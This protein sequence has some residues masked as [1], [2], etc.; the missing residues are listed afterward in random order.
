MGCLGVH[1]ALDERDL[2][3]LR[4][5]PN[6]EER[7]NYLQETIEEND[8]GSKDGWIAETDKAW[9]AIHR[10]LTDGRLGSDN[11]TYPLNHTILGGE[12]LYNSH[13]YIMQLKTPEEVRAIAV[14]LRGI[15]EGEFHQR[16]FRIDP[17]DYGMPLS[18][19]DFEYS[20]SWFTSM[21]EFYERAATAGRSVLFTASQ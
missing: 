5:Q 8:I 12:S 11:G 10:A 17:D 14:E 16:Y 2:Q 9:D 19:D 4:S 7:L 6:D 15:T 13:D 20:W 3:A 21:R 1:F 18:E